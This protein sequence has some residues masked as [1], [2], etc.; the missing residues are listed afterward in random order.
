M[1]LLLVT[2]LAMFIFIPDTA[3]PQ[4]S[5]TNIDLLQAFSLRS[6]LVLSPREI[7]PL[8]LTSHPTRYIVRD[9]ALLG[10]FGRL[11]LI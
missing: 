4:V 3:Q 2:F 5:W 6:V 7:L 9:K 1:K 8:R 11:A 10:P